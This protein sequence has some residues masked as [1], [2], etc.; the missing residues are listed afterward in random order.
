MADATQPSSPAATQS[1]HGDFLEHA[2]PRWLIDALPARRQ[3]LKDASTSPPTWLEKASPAQ[4]EAV[5]ASFLESFSA[6]TQL[7][8]TMASFQDVNDFARPLLLKALK[9]QYQVE[10]DV[11]KTLLCL[12]RPLAIGVLQ[13]EISDFQFLKLS[14]LDAALHNFEA[15]ECKEGAY[16]KTS[17]F[18]EATD[19]PGTY[20]SVTVNLKVSQFLS[21]CRS[22]DIG[23]K[24]QAY[25]QTFFYPEEGQ[26]QATLREHFIA[27]QKAA[28]KAAA[29]QAVL[30]GDILPADQRMILSVIEGEIHPW[31][32]NKQVWFRT[33]GLMKLRMT[34]CMVFLICKKYTYPNELIIYIPQD[35]VHPLKR[36][37]WAQMEAQFKRLFTERDAAKPADATPT[38]Y[39]AFFSRFVPYEKR[40]YYFSQFT[41][42]AADSP[43]DIWRSPWKKLLD[44]TTPH[45]ITGIKELPPEKPAKLEPNNDP[46][47]SPSTRTRAGK[48]IWAANID[49]WKYFYEQHREQLITDARAHAVPAADVDAK[50]RE[51]KLAHLL[52]IGML[53]LNMASMFVPVLGEV[54]MTVM[55]GQL[56]YET[57]E[58]AVE[59]GEGDLQAAKAHL[60]DVA[61]NLA[62]IAVMAG[63]GA[64]VSRWRAAKAQPVI[65]ALNEVKLPDGR[66]RLSWKVA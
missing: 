64:G 48:G 12:R 26:A 7:D 40:A 4:R 11:D 31:M 8:K 58:G 1:L 38:P 44:F 54:M 51:A 17:G 66:T 62:Q 61:E 13:T 33:L 63:V 56:L 2:S 10:V 34:G 27:S 53:G 52:E 24:Y 39:Q 32:G 25:L 36:Y 18:V 37:T 55:A 46:Y 65:E 6:Q 29:E 43:T 9:D 47:L 59:W 14:M 41:Q 23:V 57:L 45:F 42:K 22:L 19:T 28:L 5:A 60:I 16:H 20:H 21:L 35:P 50:A 49:P 15:D 3:A 30:T